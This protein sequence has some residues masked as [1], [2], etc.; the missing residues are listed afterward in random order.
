MSVF[1][2]KDEKKK[3]DSKT[4]AFEDALKRG[5]I[6][7]L[8]KKMTVAEMQNIQNCKIWEIKLKDKEE[9]FFAIILQVGA[10]SNP[11][12]SILTPSDYGVFKII[13]NIMEVDENNATPEGEEK[14]IFG[15][16]IE[17]VRLT[18]IGTRH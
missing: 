12:E 1:R 10:V 13:D 8:F 2:K 5:S 18:N 14:G 9:T 15:T 11:K 6:T 3:K 16:E 17:A 7:P 4:M